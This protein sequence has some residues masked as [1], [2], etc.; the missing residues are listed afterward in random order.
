[1]KASM[2]HCRAITKSPSTAQT[3]LA[4]KL[5]AYLAIITN[6]FT[7]G[8]ILWE[9]STGGWWAAWLDII[10]GENV[11]VVFGQNNQDT[12]TE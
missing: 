11:D 9:A 3:A 1:M 7:S 10:G 2:N 12:T 8:L 6:M 5:D 4:L